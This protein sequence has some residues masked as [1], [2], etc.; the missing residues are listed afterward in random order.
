METISNLDKLAY[1]KPE[2]ELLD[3]GFLTQIGLSSGND[4]D[5]PGSGS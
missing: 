5:G 3:V 4:G 2:I 1:Q